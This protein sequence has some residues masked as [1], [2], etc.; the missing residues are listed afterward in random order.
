LPPSLSIWEKESFFPHQDII[1]VGAGLMGLWTALELKK[2]DKGLRIAII[3]RS[4][5]PL[6]ASTRNAGFACF[7]SPTELLHNADTMGIDAMLQV[8]EMRYRGI[9]KI[10]SHFSAEQIGFDPCGGYECIN[11][12]YR[13]WDILAEKINWLN[14]LL[15]PITGT[16]SI[17][18]RVDERLPGLGLRNFDALVEN[19]TEAAL[20]SGELVAALMQKVREAGVQVLMGLEL[21]NWSEQASNIRL[22]TAQHIS[23]ITERLLFCT[24]GFSGLLLP[25]LDM[26]PARGQVI[27]TSPIP[28]LAMKGAFHFNEGFYYW[29]NL[30]DRVLLGG[31]RNNAV[32]AERTTELA[33]SEP[34][35]QALEAFLAEHLDGRYRYTIDHH[36]SGIMAF[37]GSRR[38]V[39]EKISARVY[40]S[41]ACNGM[42]VALTPVV[43][44]QAAALLR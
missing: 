2:Q 6:G 32:D 16:A 39:V 15:Q 26:E 3:E 34:I 24:N 31:A 19:T 13:H 11:R 21:A 18:Q 33:G 14:Q 28:G 1:I 25:Q 40:A 30:G 38:P 17:F 37:T 4:P 27:V 29:R 42:G 43:A 7:G 10:R 20:H 35:R 8:V 44:E 12:D 5:V 9:E 22:E 23:V 41:I 36:W